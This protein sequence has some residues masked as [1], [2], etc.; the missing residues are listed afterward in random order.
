MA[1]I[2]TPTAHAR[3]RDMTDRA[4]CSRRSEG[5]DFGHGEVAASRHVNPDG[6]LGG[7][8]AATAN[9]DQ[10][11]HVDPDAVVFDNARVFGRSYVFDE[12]QVFGNARVLD[13]S[14]ISGTAR[15]F[16]NATIDA[17]G[18]IDQAEVR[19]DACLLD[20]SIAAGAAQVAGRARVLGNAILRDQVIAT[21]DVWIDGAELAGTTVVAGRTIVQHHPDETPTDAGEP[22]RSTAVVVGKV[23]P[24][25]C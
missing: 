20:G 24:S 12:A 15:V 11:A 10:V 14:L 7:W 22:R 1:A 4:G 18:V 3:R 23:T 19:E 2:E 16:D 25:T 9:V 21:D 5:H 8:V 6:T 13:G 17:A